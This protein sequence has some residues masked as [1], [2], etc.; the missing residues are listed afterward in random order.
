MADKIQF[1]RDTAARWSQFNPVLMEGEIGYVTDDPNQYKIGDGVTAWNDLPLRGFDG[2]LVHTLGDSETA[3]MSQKGVKDALIYGTE[4]FTDM[5][6]NKNN[7]VEI[8]KGEITSGY[9]L[10]D[11][12]ELQENSG[13]N[14]TDYIQ[15]YPE[16][17]NYAITL[18]VTVTENHSQIAF[19]DNAK[20]YKGCIHGG[21]S[22]IPLSRVK[23]PLNCV[24]IRIS[25]SS[26]DSSF[27]FYKYDRVS[28]LSDIKEIA[29]QHPINLFDKKGHINKGY[30]LNIIGDFSEHADY[31]VSD[32]IKFNP[33]EVVTINT[34]LGSSAFNAQY[35][36]SFNLISTVECSIGKIE[37]AENARY[38]RFSAPLSEIEIAMACIGELPNVYVPYDYS[39]QPYNVYVDSLFRPAT[40]TIEQ[41]HQIP[42][43]DV[44]DGIFGRN[45]NQGYFTTDY[46]EVHVKE[47]PIYIFLKQVYVSSLTLIELYDK[48][49]NLIKTIHGDKIDTGY[50]IINKL[51]ELCIP[52]SCKYVRYSQPE[53][54][55]DNTG[56]FI[57]KEYKNF[58][59]IVKEILPVNRV[60]TEN[61][62]VVW[63]GTSIPTGSPYPP[64]CV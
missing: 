16:I 48:D 59:D 27:A 47:S 44:A 24:Y 18:G 49:K 36:A 62:N 30:A 63:V 5:F 39:G 37:A 17:F 60:F 25:F 9:V 53:S 15:V 7:L 42:Y 58:D 51:L 34:G 13:W 29:Y 61:N 52:N 32:Y 43:G 64:K 10:L 46:I 6:Y 38:F 45:L 54:C 28:S 22:A 19:Y 3:A 35:D 55:I 21:F 23:I 26:V 2:T 12:G 8:D 50:Y 56:L 4:C 11:N 41:L 20:V 1:R 40:V 31:Y 14:L 57:L 33:G